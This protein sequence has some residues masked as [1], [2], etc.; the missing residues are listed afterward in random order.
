[1]SIKTERISYDLEE[2]HQAES[3]NKRKY[4][5]SSEMVSSCSKQ[6]KLTAEQTSGFKVYKSNKQPSTNRPPSTESL[7]SLAS[8]LSSISSSSTLSSLTY[9]PI[10]NA[11]ENEQDCGV[12]IKIKSSCYLKEECSKLRLKTCYQTKFF[13]NLRDYLHAQPFDVCFLLDQNQPINAHK[14]IVYNSSTYLRNKIDQNDYKHPIPVQYIRLEGVNDAESF[15]T[16][17]EYM[18]SAGDELSMSKLKL[19]DLKCMSQLLE[20]DDLTLLL[21]NLIEKYPI[22]PVASLAEQQIQQT[23]HNSLQTQL[24]LLAATNQLDLQSILH[25][26]Y[27][28]NLRATLSPVQLALTSQSS[29]REDLFFTNNQTFTKVKNYFQL[30]LEKNATS[31]EIDTISREFL[32][33][34]KYIYPSMLRQTESLEQYFENFSFVNLSKNKEIKESNRCEFTRHSL[35]IFCLNCSSSGENSN[36]KL[37]N[38]VIPTELNFTDL[39]ALKDDLKKVIGEFFNELMDKLNL[40]RSGLNYKAILNRVCYLKKPSNCKT[41]KLET[42]KTSTDCFRAIVEYSRSNS[43]FSNELPYVLV[44]CHAS[45]NFN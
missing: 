9:Q 23:E 8:T 21:E 1:M 6:T 5:D 25:Q 2:Y 7:S 32:I 13:A 38:Y 45:I 24:S 30:V 41:I 33:K 14:L 18:Y 31:L 34:D 28:N 3:T 27:L 4:T 43:D 11:Y 12:Q 26:I 10:I 20:L 19:N 22:E 39:S 16:C 40:N 37:E 42:I 36:F 29:P 15:R 17:L 44:T 35:F